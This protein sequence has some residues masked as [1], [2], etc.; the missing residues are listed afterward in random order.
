MHTVTFLPEGRTVRVASGTRIAEAARAAGIPFETPCGGASICGKCKV[1]LAAEALPRVEQGGACLLCEEERAEGCVL[2]CAT[3]IRGDIRVTL[4]ARGDAWTQIQISGRDASSDAAL[5]PEFGKDYAPERDETTVYAGGAPRGVEEGDTRGALYGI[6]A[7]IGTTT[8]VAELVDMTSGRTMAAL[9]SVNPQTAYGQDV[10]SRIKF[11]SDPQGLAT[12]HGL[13]LSELNGLTAGLCARAGIGA[14][15]VYEIVLSGNTAMLHLAMKLDPAPLGRVPFVSR[16]RGGESFGAAE[17]GFAISPLGR[18]YLPPILS[19]YVGADITA[20]ILAARLHER[21]G[22]SLFI[23]IGTNGEMVMADNGRLC[24]ASAAAGPAFEGM[25]IRFGM[26]AATGAIERFT[27]DGTGEPVLR[28]IG[29]APPAGICGSGLIDIV[30]ELVAHG[31]IDETGRFAE[32]DALP[33]PLAARMT[34][35]AGKPAFSV[36]PGIPLTQRDVRQVQLAKG[37]LRAGV[38]TLL[39]IVKTSAERLDRVLIAGAFGYRLRAESLIHMGLLPAACAGR[40]EFL[41]N[42]SQS[43]GRAF[44]LNRAHRARIAA[45]VPATEVVELANRADFNDLFIDCLNF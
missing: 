43:G 40:I 37:A 26:R 19:A 1:K 4:P 9:S 42:T 23:D 2:A 22:R 38:E 21:A 11:A 8:L 32:A 34:E 39:A 3:S 15:C 30:G 31:V 10:L 44:L 45:L 17:S 25:N 16:L 41:G 20:G 36:A 35:D 33:P 24:A 13:L 27:I 28:T 29:D 14:D 5:A 7:D 18:V 12:L 6:V